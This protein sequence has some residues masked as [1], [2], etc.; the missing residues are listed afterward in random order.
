MAES[1]ISVLTGM[2]L[3]KKALLLAVL[4]LVAMKR[5]KFL[6]G[7]KNPCW[8]DV[9]KE[10]QEIVTCMPYFHLLGADKCGSTDLFDRILQHPEME[11]A[12]CEG[13]PM[14]LWDFRGWPRIPQNDH[15][16]EPVIMTPHLMRHM[17]PDPKLLVILRNPADRLY[18]DYYFLGYGNSPE[19]FHKDAIRAVAM[20]ENCLKIRTRKQCIFDMDMYVNLPMRIHISCYS[21]FLKEWMRVF[22]RESFL[23]LRNE[24]Y[25]HDIRNHMNMVFS[26]LNMSRLPDADM[27][28][29]SNAKRKHVTQ[30]KKNKGP[31]FEST[32]VL[33]NNFFEPYNKELVTLLQDDRFLWKDEPKTHT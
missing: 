18:S 11:P 5:P 26:F 24:D 12:G 10:G 21:V 17:Y 20:I 9:T 32:R 27:D 23:I 7:Y 2:R 15:L 19:K 33:L 22:P 28:V 14:D 13:T 29:I 8:K 6:P 31:M 1:T 30:S 3:K 25:G 4:S 16:A